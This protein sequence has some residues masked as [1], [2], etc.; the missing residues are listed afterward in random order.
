MNS[1]RFALV[2]IAIWVAILTIGI[3][4]NAPAD[5]NDANLIAS[6]NHLGQLRSITSARSI[7]FDNPFFQD[8]GTNGR[9]CV[10][11]HQPENAWSI[12]PENVQ[13]R[14][15]STSGDDP[16]FRN[17]D[18]SNCEGAVPSSL[19]EK[20]LAYSLLLDRGLIRVGVDVPPGAEFAI[21]HVD[22]PMHCGSAT[23]DAS[24]YRRPLPST[25][26][27]F[28]SA[29]MWDGRESTPTTTILED[30][31]RQADDATMGHAEAKI[32]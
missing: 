12:T 14:F 7:D 18:G 32:G 9:R 5:S 8:L 27:R 19:D 25:N 15:L 22:D 21:D 1:Q 10:S 11:C 29:V 31:A 13:T 6:G 26:L 28:L 16:I 23:N 4:T 30:L 24:L 3:T 20:R 17:N 2:T